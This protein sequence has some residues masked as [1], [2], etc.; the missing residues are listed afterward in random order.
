[1]PPRKKTE[2]IVEVPVLPPFTSENHDV[3][4][5]FADGTFP[6][7][8]IHTMS[9]GRAMA[10]Q[11]ACYSMTRWPPEKIIAIV[12]LTVDKV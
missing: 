12:G 9:K 6:D 3:T 4:V 8:V 5:M 11:T 10:I 2:Q 7:E 1:M